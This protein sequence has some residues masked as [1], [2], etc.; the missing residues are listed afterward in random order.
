MIDR[1]Y[2]GVLANWDGQAVPAERQIREARTLL[3]RNGGRS[4]DVASPSPE[5]HEVERPCKSPKADGR[6]R[7]GDPFITSKS[8]GL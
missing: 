7:T 1:H 6:I 2:A 3:A 4:V 5:G 8:R